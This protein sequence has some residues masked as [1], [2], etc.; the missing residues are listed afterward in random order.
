MGS[1]GSSLGRLR[2]TSGIAILLV[3][4]TLQVC[5]VASAAT[6]GALLKRY[7]D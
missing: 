2:D 3:L 5:N 7:E 1:A 4:R 6:L